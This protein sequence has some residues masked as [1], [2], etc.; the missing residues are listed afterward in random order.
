[1][2]IMDDIR[3]ALEAHL[4]GTV[5]VPSTIFYE[6]VPGVQDPDNAHLRSKL[7]PTSRRPAVV[8]PAPQQRHQGLYQ[9]MVCTPKGVGTGTA[10]GY[11]DILLARFESHTSIAGAS[12]T[13]S[14]EYSEIGPGYMEDAFYCIPVLV[15]WY[16]YA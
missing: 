8:G 16:V 4:A 3:Q 7:L 14:T 10:L 11:A 6:N 13:M 1:M 12:V 9:I 5:G 15:A 2:S